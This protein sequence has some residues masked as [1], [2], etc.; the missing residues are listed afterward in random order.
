MLVSTLAVIT[1]LLSFTNKTE[2]RTSVKGNEVELSDA[3]SVNLQNIQNAYKA[4]VTASAKYEAFSEQAEEEGYHKIAIMFDALSKAK[5]IHA[6]NHKAVLEEADQDVPEIEP[7]FQVKT[8][9]ENLRD[10]IADENYKIN[11]MYPEYIANAEKADEQS[12][13]KSLNYAFKTLPKHKDYNDRALAA[14]E[15]NKEESLPSVYFVCSTCGNMY[16]SNIPERCEVSG[17]ESQE[18]IQVPGSSNE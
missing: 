12:S 2:I 7:E 9:R 14:M 15:D 6:E 8:T 1:M 10:A 5:N 4:E 13:L 11:T 3:K 16:D 18:F 17:T